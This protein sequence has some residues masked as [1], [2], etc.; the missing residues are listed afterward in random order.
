MRELS[1]VLPGKEIVTTAVFK[2]NPGLNTRDLAEVGEWLLEGK[3][4]TTKDIQTKLSQLRRRRLIRWH[5]YGAPDDVVV[6]EL[7]VAHSLVV[8]VH[9][10]EA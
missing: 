8:P 1:G 4:V 9:D 5:I 3:K 7:S 6:P 2:D 10:H